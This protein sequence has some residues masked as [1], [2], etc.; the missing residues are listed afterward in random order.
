MEELRVGELFEK[1]DNK[2]ILHLSKCIHKVKRLDISKTRITFDGFKRLSKAI[3]NL[4]E[5]V[6]ILFYLPFKKNI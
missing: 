1:L 3:M 5:P 4:N 6:C 2:E